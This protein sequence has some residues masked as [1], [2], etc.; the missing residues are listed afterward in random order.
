MLSTGV[1]GVPLPMDRVLAGVGSAVTA[2]A[3]DGGESAA[4]GDPHHRSLAE[5]VDG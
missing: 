4:I 3:A 2:L 1:I 5:A